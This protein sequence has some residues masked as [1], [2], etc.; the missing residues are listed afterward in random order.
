LQSVFFTGRALADLVRQHAP[1][2]LGPFLH[3]LE[4]LCSSP[5]VTIVLV[6]T[7]QL[8]VTVSRVRSRTPPFTMLRCNTPAQRQNPPG[9]PHPAP[10]PYAEREA[11]SSASLAR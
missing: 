6:L 8:C 5:T 4:H 11:A 2:N 10:S 7:N 9:L 3:V 1:T